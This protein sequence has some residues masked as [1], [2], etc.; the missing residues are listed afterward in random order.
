MHINRFV[1]LSLIACCAFH[2][3]ATA[4]PLLSN[5]GFETNGGAGTTV[6]N[7][8]TVVSQNGSGGSWFA[9]TAGLSPLN[10]FPVLTPPEGSFAAM[11]DSGSPG[12]NALL[13]SFTVSSAG[14]AVLSF[15][16]AIVNLGPDFITPD[17]LDYTAGPNEQV[18]VDILTANAGAF[19]LGTSV[20][21]NVFQPQSGDTADM[22]DGA[23]QQVS[24]DISSVVGSGGTYQLRFAEVDT[25][26]PLLFGVDDASISFTAD[27]TP[28]PPSG[29]VP[30][31]GSLLLLATG[32]P[33]L[34]ALR[35]RL[36]QR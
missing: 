21:L 22:N 28:P 3:S 12:A 8:W 19:D 35:K 13:Q 16:Y 23:Y 14:T 26:G 32:L 30:E 27:Q 6:L 29:D 33:L 7:N 5:G 17:T 1:W 25:Q 11:T 15:D 20:L 31:P 10:G 4:S 18:R 9:Q 34:S 24:L 36:P 2:S